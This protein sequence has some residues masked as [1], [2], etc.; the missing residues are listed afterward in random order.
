MCNAPYSISPSPLAKRFMTRP[1]YHDRLQ[2]PQHGYSECV[3]RCPRS[4]LHGPSPLRQCISVD[5]VGDLVVTTASHT[6][7]PVRSDIL[8][9]GSKREVE[10]PS[11]LKDADTPCPPYLSFWVADHRE[12]EAFWHGRHPPYAAYL[13]SPTMKSLPNLGI[14]TPVTNQVDMDIDG[15]RAPCGSTYPNWHGTRE[16]PSNSTRS[17]LPKPVL[18]PE[19]GL[20]LRQLRITSARSLFPQLAGEMQL[21]LYKEIR[22]AMER[23]EIALLSNDRFPSAVSK[24]R[25]ASLSTTVSSGEYITATRG[26]KRAYASGPMCCGRNEDRAK[27]KFRATLARSSRPASVVPQTIEKV[28]YTSAGRPHLY[29]TLYLDEEGILERSWADSMM[30]RNPPVDLRKIVL[31]ASL[32]SAFHRARS[33]DRSSLGCVTI[34]KHSLEC[35]GLGL[36]A[37]QSTGCLTAS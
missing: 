19:A 28:V 32:R 2:I 23:E 5:L 9:K 22:A 12:R 26:V 13:A 30:H 35:K 16:M 21:L 10:G 3:L 4:I 7:S 17:S 11:L 36:D 33:K 24:E 27:K 25:S 31:C 29:A 14:A 20:R 1:I 8:W 15:E 37:C 18:N 6:P 34:R